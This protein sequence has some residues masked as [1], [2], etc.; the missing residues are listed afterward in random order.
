MDQD[1]WQISWWRTLNKGSI[2]NFDMFMGLFHGFYKD[3]VRAK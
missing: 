3:N 2:D 1:G